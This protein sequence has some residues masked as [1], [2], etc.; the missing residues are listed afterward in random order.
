M[1]LERWL[2]V[3]ESCGPIHQLGTSFGHAPKTSPSAPMVH[4]DEALLDQTICL[5]DVVADQFANGSLR[6]LVHCHSTTHYI[7]ISFS[8]TAFIRSHSFIHSHNWLFA[9]S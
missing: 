5:A 1:T 4:T 6:V 3:T 7:H 9:G 8:H 2:R